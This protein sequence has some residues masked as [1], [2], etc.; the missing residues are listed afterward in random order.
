MT[1]PTAN[2]ASIAQRYILPAI[3]V[4]AVATIVGA[5]FQLRFQ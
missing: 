4:L 1:R 2:Y 3:M 5:A